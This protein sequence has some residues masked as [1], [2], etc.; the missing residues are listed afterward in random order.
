MPN[1]IRGFSRLLVRGVLLVL[2]LAVVAA[3]VLVFADWRA[4]QADEVRIVEVPFMK[5][6]S[7]AF[8][9]GRIVFIQGDSAD[10]PDLLAHE[11]VHVCQWEEQG[12]TFLWD[13]TAEYTEN[14][15]ETGDANE[16]Y[17]ELSFEQEARLGEVDCDLGSYVVVL[18]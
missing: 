12:I 14:L 2:A 3:G 15:V 13:Y 11:L 7:D 18:P 4:R 6:G 17:L 16:A 10:D 5:P 9:T 1:L 8:A